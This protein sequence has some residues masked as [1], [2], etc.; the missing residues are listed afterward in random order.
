MEGQPRETEASHL[1]T[2]VKKRI[3]RLGREAARRARVT[4]ERHE[5]KAKYGVGLKGGATR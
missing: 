5:A 3:R 2:L 1:N 4:A